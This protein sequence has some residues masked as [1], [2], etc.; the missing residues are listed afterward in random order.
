V[1]AEQ[2]DYGRA[3]A[4]LKESLLLGRDI[5]ARELLATGLESLAW[6]AAARGQADRAARLGGVAEALRGV[7]GAPLPPDE[8][9]SHERAVNAVRTVLGEEG[10][11]VAWAAGRALTL[12]EAIAQALA[13]GPPA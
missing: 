6:V 1:A 13:V 8:R 4:L 10:T 11:T 9:A 12:D 7:L 2:G 5:G 3:T